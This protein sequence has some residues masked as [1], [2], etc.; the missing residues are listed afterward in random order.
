[1]TVRRQRLIGRAGHALA[2]L[3]LAVP[4][5]PAEP[6]S[7]T[8]RTYSSAPA[9]VIP[10][11]LPP[12][13]GTPQSVSDTIA[14]PDSG[15]IQDV[16]VTV[17]IQHP[18]HGDLSIELT[19]PGGG[20]T[21]RLINTEG[22]PG[23]G[24]SNVTFDDEAAGLPPGFVVNGTCLVDQTYQPAPGSLADFDGLEVNGTWTLTVADNFTSDA[25]DCDC[26]G[27][28]VGPDCPRTL[29][30][31]SLTIDFEGDD[32]GPPPLGCSEVFILIAV[33]LLL[34]AILWLLVSKARP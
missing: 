6:A 15:A 33:I 28:V 22:G 8:V 11:A 21:V 34:L 4:A 10:D 23:D 27:F 16:D 13:P 17:T 3:V 20:V 24:L 32:A 12:G 26:D 19:D 9:A 7:A 14:V 25:S 2:L 1:M 29:D 5:L 18:G 31:W 30:E